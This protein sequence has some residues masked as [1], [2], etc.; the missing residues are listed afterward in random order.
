LSAI[1]DTLAIVIPVVFKRSDGVD[2]GNT[3]KEIGLIAF[4]HRNNV[5]ISF[6]RKEGKFVPGN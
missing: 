3:G 4:Y 2:D 5:H 6:L 1:P